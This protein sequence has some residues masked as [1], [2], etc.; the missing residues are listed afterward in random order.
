MVG[1]KTREKSGGGKAKALE[2][3]INSKLPFIHWSTNAAD[4][5]SGRL[6]GIY[7]SQML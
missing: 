4:L 1:R 2:T 5:V 7:L 3:G 6:S